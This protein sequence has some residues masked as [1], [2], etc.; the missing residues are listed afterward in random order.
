MYLTHFHKRLSL[1]LADYGMVLVL[2]LLCAFFTVVAWSEQ[3][4]GGAAAAKELA[5][6]IVAEGGGKARVLIVVR[7]APKDEGFA[8][9]LRQELEGRGVPV[10]GV[11]RGQ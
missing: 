10:V 11:V 4:P 5:G 3:R 1:V 8:A 7:A 9:L 2:L 6:R